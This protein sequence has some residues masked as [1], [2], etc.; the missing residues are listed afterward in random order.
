MGD[1][2]TWSRSMR[3]EQPPQ[4]PTQEEMDTGLICLLILARFYDL[5]ADGAQ[6]RPISSRSPEKKKVSAT[7]LGFTQGVPPPDARESDV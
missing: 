7:V 5:P 2:D 6:L 3:S 1:S 4:D